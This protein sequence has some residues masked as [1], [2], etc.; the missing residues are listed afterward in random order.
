MVWVDFV[1]PAIII[2]SALFSVMRGFVREAI[3]LFGWI[4]AFWIALHFANSL[5]EMFLSSISIPSIR[6]VIAFTILFVLTLLLAALINHL[7][8]YLVKQT[9]LTNTDRLIGMLFGVARG[10]VIVSILVLLAGFTTIPQDPWWNESVL[11]KRFEH[12]ANFLRDTVAPEIAGKL[13]N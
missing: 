2:V 9:G 7:V 4:A 8:G 11:I 10:G 12:V 5:A 1:I 6:L 3:S 13:N